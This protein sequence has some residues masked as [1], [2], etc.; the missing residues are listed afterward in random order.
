MPSYDYECAECGH[1]FEEFQSMSD[2]VLT[3]CPECGK[4]GLKRLIGGGLGI[5]F[6]GSGFYVNDSKSTK[7]ST[8]SGG[9]AKSG[10][11]SKPSSESG[12]KKAADTAPKAPVS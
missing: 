5:I 2:P 12:T 3:S 7:S 9:E 10:S 4:E 8:V 6:K 1:F 11:E